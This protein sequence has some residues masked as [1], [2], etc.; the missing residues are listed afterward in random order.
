MG[1]TRLEAAAAA[2]GGVAP[3]LV[4][5]LAAHLLEFELRRLPG[6]FGLADAVAGAGADGVEF[7]LV[8]VFGIEAFGLHLLA[9]DLHA[10]VG[11]LVVGTD[12]RLLGLRALYGAFVSEAVEFVF[13]GICI[14]EEEGL[15]LLDN[16]T[17]AAEHLADD[18][19]NRGNHRH[20]EIGFHLA[21]GVHRYLNRRLLDSADDDIRGGNAGTHGEDDDYYRD[22]NRQD[23]DGNREGGL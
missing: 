12:L 11:D 5:K 16:V 19:G 21:V 1:D 20:L 23:W 2:C 6:E 17:L 13:L 9:P 18:R 15:A 8:G 10:E 4:G 14:E 7:P 3:L 22:D